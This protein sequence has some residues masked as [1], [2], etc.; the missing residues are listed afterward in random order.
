[1]SQHRDPICGMMVESDT[2]TAHTTYQSRDVFFCSDECRKAFEKEPARYFDRLEQ[3][4]PY[5][6]KGMAGI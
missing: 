4:P 6:V 5:T 3:E 1:M 2:A